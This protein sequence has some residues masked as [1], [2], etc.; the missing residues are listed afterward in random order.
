MKAKPLYSYSAGRL[1]DAEGNAVVASPAQL[2]IDDFAAGLAE[3]GM[4]ALAE[5]GA[6]LILMRLSLDMIAPESD[7]FNEAALSRLREVLKKAEEKRVAAVIAMECAGEAKPSDAS[8]P[9]IGAA[10][11]TARRLKDCSSL[12]GFA[13]PQWAD[14]NFLLSLA[15]RL[16]KKHPT[17]L[18]FIPPGGGGQA[19]G[20]ESAKLRRPPFVSPEFYPQGWL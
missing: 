20:D 10:E 7:A 6:N 14:D 4:A 17:L 12:I 9:F 18:V 15:A 5:K 19:Q 16:E 3:A 1:T 13:A 2:R 11:H 8:E